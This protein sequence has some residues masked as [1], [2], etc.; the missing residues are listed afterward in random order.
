MSDP[1]H[2]A[3]A[4]LADSPL[5]KSG[6]FLPM[7]GCDAPIVDGFDLDAPINSLAYNSLF[8]SPPHPAPLDSH[9]F[10]SDS[11]PFFTNLA[12]TA[13]PLRLSPPALDVDPASVPEIISY[14]PPTGR[15]GTRIVV[16]VRVAYDASQATSFALLVGS[17][18][19]ECSASLIGFD[20]A[21]KYALSITAPSFGATGFPSTNVPIHLIVAPLGAK[22]QQA[23]VGVFSYD[24][25]VASSPV[26]ARKRR[27]SDASDNSSA[28]SKQQCVHDSPLSQYISTPVSAVAVPAAAPCLHYGAPPMGW[29]S[30]DDVLPNPN[31]IVTPPAGAAAPSPSAPSSAEN[32]TL[33]RT[34]TIN[35]ALAGAPSPPP[36]GL[37]AKAVLDLHGDLDSMPNN[38][39]KQEVSDRRRL[40]QFSRQQNG[41]TVHADL[42]PVAP[43]ER[44]PH[45]ICISCILWDGKDECFVTSVDT[46]YLL[47][48]L[49]GVRFTVEEKN[50]IRR[51]LEGF[52]PLTV[53]KG[54]PDTADFFK[55]IMGFPNPKPRNIEKDVKVFPWR[56]LSQ[57]LTKIIGKYVSHS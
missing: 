11:Q 33:I 47:E 27:F 50:R 15:E 30:A 44:D 18:R 10:S 34:S 20:G 37:S 53:S 51:N 19:C 43:A 17:Q 28:S 45:G 1:D 36:Y 49:V 31:F 23:H 42:K 2:S 57:A 56:I 52:H 9:A 4:A 21:F 3:F 41:N 29:S 55:V 35:Q 48:A 24:H 26:S 39:T 22:I 16:C 46:I 38:W 54:K 14:G 7:A 6:G 13:P 25:S 5:T 40:V 8:I 32:P 12:D